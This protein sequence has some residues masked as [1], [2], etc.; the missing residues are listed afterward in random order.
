LALDGG[1]N[2]AFRKAMS[3]SGACRASH[4]LDVH[5]NC[6]CSGPLLRMSGAM[7]SAPAR[8]PRLSGA[9]KLP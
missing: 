1:G 3:P 4:F 9:D 7:L 2:F 5:I 8:V 6:S